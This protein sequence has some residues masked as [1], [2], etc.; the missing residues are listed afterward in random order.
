MN[1]KKANNADLDSLIAN[2][3]FDYTRIDDLRRW[4]IYRMA[5]TKRPLEEKLTLFWHGH[6][7]TSVRKVELPYRMYTQNN[8]MRNLGLGNF[9]DLLLAM[10]KDPAMIVWLDN[11]QNK[12][13]QPNENYAREVMEL[14]S[15]GIGH[16]SERDIK[17]SARAFT[18]WQTHQDGFFF[19]ASQHDY[20]DK[21]FLG[22]TGKFNGDDIIDIIVQQPAVGKFLAQKLC[23]FFVADEPTQAIVTDVAKAYKPNGDNIKEMLRVLFLHDDFQSSYLKKIKSPVEFVIGSLKSLEVTQLDSDVASQIGRMG[24]SLFDPPN[25]KGWDGGTCSGLPRTQ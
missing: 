7:A 10:T 20:G 2:Q 21:T 19:N 4:W 24:Q 14:F 17:E 6:F 22:Q 9:H 18:G 5:F 23:K 25:V 12:K 1:R 8:V 3:N 13:G 11:Q 15:L 16:Y